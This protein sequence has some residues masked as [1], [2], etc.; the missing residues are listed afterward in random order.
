[1]AWHSLGPLT[2]ASAGVILAAMALG[3]GGQTDLPAEA[4][5]PSRPLIQG[6]VIDTRDVPLEGRRGAHRLVKVRTSAGRILVADLGRRDRLDK[7][8]KLRRGESIALRGYWGRINGRPVL[9]ATHIADLI[10]IDRPEA[11]G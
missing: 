9:F 10:P 6:R 11:N 8:V 2:W 7:D 1:M 4:A 5:A 3:A